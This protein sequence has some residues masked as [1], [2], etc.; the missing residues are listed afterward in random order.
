MRPSVHVFAA[1]VVALFAF[2]PRSAAAYPWMVQHGYTACAQCHVDPAGAGTLTDYGRAQGEILL[3]THYGKEKGDPEKISQFLFGAAK[4]PEV[5]ELQADVRGMVIPQPGNVRAILMQADARA[6]VHAGIFTASASIGGV[7]EGGELAWLS[8]GDSGWNL[9]SREYWAG[10]TPVKGLMIKAGRMNL[11]FGIRTEDHI[12]YVRSATGT[13]INDDQ[14]VGLA[15]S[16]GTRK[17][18]AELMGIAGNFQVRPDDFRKRGYSAY[19]AY[20]ISKKLEVGISSLF[21][22]SQAD[23]ET[24]APRTFMAHGLFTRASPVEK[25]AVMAEADVLLDNQD[26]TRTQGI[27]GLAVVDYEPVQGVHVMG[28][29]EYCAR[30]LPAKGEGVWRAGIASQWFLASR[31]DVRGDLGYG[32]IFCTP[33]AEPRP[34]GLVQAHFYL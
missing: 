28:L 17:I 1:L 7:S 3:R 19:A 23:V 13:T 18:R 22:K 6:A 16:Y 25:L 15:V 34:Y 20:A 27:A 29:G 10:I 14:Q 12:L 11:P 32:V 21:T 26:G 4:L 5:L 24:L 31:V 30:D 9:V 8:S 2:F 33:G